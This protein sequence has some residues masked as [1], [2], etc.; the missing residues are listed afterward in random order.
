[1]YLIHISNQNNFVILRWNNTIK[2]WFLHPLKTI[3]QT[4]FE[5]FLSIESRFNVIKKHLLRCS[6]NNERNIIIR[7]FIIEILWSQFS[8]TSLKSRNATSQL[9]NKNNSWIW[10]ETIW[11][12]ISI[13]STSLTKY[14]FI[15]LNWRTFQIFIRIT[16]LT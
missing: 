4:L 1:M 14:R 11:Q 16:H 3:L 2:F 6:T 10:G 15:L 5:L 7:I 13:Y 12:Y 9:V 8:P